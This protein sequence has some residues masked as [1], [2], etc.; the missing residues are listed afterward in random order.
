MLTCTAK[1]AVNA[2]SRVFAKVTIPFLIN[3]CCIKVAI[4]HDFLESNGLVNILSFVANSSRWKMPHK[5]ELTHSMISPP[6]P[7]LAV[8]QQL[9]FSH[10][11]RDNHNTPIVFFLRE[12]MI[13]EFDEALLGCYY[14]LASDWRLSKKGIDKKGLVTATTF[15]VCG[16]LSDMYEWYQGTYLA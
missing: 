16:N 12:N 3:E 10:Y 1:W 2:F 13:E 14:A 6:G 11:S 5:K 15:I 7:F 4:M 9:Y 8:S